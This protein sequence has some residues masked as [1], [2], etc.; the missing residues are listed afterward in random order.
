MAHQASKWIKQPLCIKKFPG[1]GGNVVNAQMR[2]P[3]AVYVVIAIPKKKI[4][5]NASLYSRLWMLPASVFE[6]TGISRTLRADVSEINT[7]AAVKSL[8]LLDLLFSI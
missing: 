8:I 1:T 7:P 5:L 2:C 6:K 4:H 3:I